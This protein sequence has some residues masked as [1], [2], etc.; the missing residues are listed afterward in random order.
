MP[1][2]DDMASVPRGLGTV[3][4][5]FA[6]SEGARAPGKRRRGR[7]PE[8]A[9]GIRAPFG[10][11]RDETLEQY[12]W[13]WKNHE[14]IDLFVDIAALVQLA[15]VSVDLG[16]DVDVDV[17]VLPSRE[18]H[19]NPLEGPGIGMGN[20]DEGQATHPGPGSSSPFRIFQRACLEKRL[21]HSEAVGRS[22]DAVRG[23]ACGVCVKKGTA[24]GL[25]GPA[26]PPGKRLVS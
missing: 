5:G 9:S 13:W 6:S 20:P 14:S 1:F 17:D 8:Q 12:P 26:G 25:E 11:A 16:V 4:D 22:G 15:V 10:Q 2:E 18:V 24:A 23:R 19:A 21:L 7:T 3:V